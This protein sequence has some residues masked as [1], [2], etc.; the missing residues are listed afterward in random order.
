MKSKKLSDRDGSRMNVPLVGVRMNGVLGGFLLSLDSI[1]HI[2]E[3][4][5]YGGMFYRVY[6]VSNVQNILTSRRFESEIFDVLFKV[7]NYSLLQQNL[8]CF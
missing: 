1:T 2:T 5:G 6:R 4:T 7:F 8:L 3:L